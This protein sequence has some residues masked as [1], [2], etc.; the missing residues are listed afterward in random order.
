MTRNLR[1]GFTLIE[2]IVVIG[3][4]AV[5]MALLLP[6]IQAVRVAAASARCA[7][8]MRQLGLAVHGYADTRAGDLPYPGLVPTHEVFILPNTT[9]SLTGRSMSPFFH[10]LPHI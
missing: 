4:V 8:Q 5:L 7:N 10:L 6:A 2:L 1:R 3:I 9:L